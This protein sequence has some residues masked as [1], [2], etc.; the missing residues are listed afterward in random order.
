M[1]SVGASVGSGDGNHP[2]HPLLES[3][4][5]TRVPTARSKLGQDPKGVSLAREY[6]LSIVVATNI[7]P[8]AHR[9][10]G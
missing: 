3:H 8:S 7:P 5:N 1:A 6:T 2:P 9:K 4:V 10:F